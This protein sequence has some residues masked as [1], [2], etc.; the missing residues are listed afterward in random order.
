MTNHEDRKYLCQGHGRKRRYKDAHCMCPAYIY[1]SPD[2]L[3]AIIL[4]FSKLCVLSRYML[5]ITVFSI[6]TI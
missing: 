2:L 3:M 5:Y 4:Y 1:K 6:L